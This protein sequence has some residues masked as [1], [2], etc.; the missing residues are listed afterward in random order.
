MKNKG[1]RP[2]S[3]KLEMKKKKLQQK[4]QKYKGSQETTVSNYMAIKWSILKNTANW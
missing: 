2:K 3:M 1:E 4:R